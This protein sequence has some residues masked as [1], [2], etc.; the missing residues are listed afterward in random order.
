M[1][2]VTGLYIQERHVIC[3]MQNMLRNMN[4]HY[5]EQKQIAFV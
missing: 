5:A 4:F 3:L 1:E 2:A